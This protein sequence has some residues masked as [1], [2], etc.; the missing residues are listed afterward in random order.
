MTEPSTFQRWR[1]FF[2]GRVQGVGF[3][4][5]VARLARQHELSGF[6]CN[7]TRGVCVE[8][9]GKASSL[10]AFQQQCLSQLPPAARLQGVEREV[11]GWQ[12]EEGF[13]I[14]DS[15]A[16]DDSWLWPP[17]DLVTC[18]ACFAEFG[19]PADRRFGYPFLNCTHCGPRYSLLKALPYDRERTSM[20]TFVMCPE[21]QREYESEE[22]RRYHA[23]PTACPACGPELTGRLGAKDC[24][25]PEV[26]PAIV[27]LLAQ[28]GTV[29]L[30]GVG[31]FQLLCDATSTTAVQRLRQRKHRPHKPLAVLMED[32]SQV[33][34]HCEVS[35][36]EERWL[37]D[38]SN[39]IVLLKHRPQSSLCSEV[40][41]GS[42]ETGVMLPT[43]PL[44]L[45]L[46]RAVGRP[47]VCTS[48]N[49]SGQPLCT[50]NDDALLSLETLADGWLLHDREIEQ[51][52]DDAVMCVVRGNPFWLRCGRGIAPQVFP[53]MTTTIPTMAAGGQWK[54]SFALVDNYRCWHSPY[55]G[56]MDNLATF[57]RW[58][59]TLQRLRE[60]SGIEPALLVS[61]LHPDYQ[62]TRW[63]ERRARASNIDHLRVQH[64]H[65][66]FFSVVA[67]H[68]LT[69]PVFG[70]I[71]DGTGYGLD[72]SI[73]G[74]EGFLWTENKMERRVSLLPFALPGGDKAILEP[75]RTVLALWH[76]CEAKHP[77]PERLQSL[78][79]PQQ[80]H[81]LRQMLDKGLRSPLCSSLG[82]LFDAVAVMSGLVE[83]VSFEGEAAMRLEWSQSPESAPLS[84]P[85]VKNLDSSG[86]RFLWDWRPMFRELWRGLEKG[87]SPDAL[88]S[89]FHRALIAMGVE[90][91]QK[92][93]AGTVVLSGGCF[94]NQTL[95][96]GLSAALQEAGAEVFWNQQ[97]PCHDEGL[98][99]GQIAAVKAGFG[100][101]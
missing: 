70:L 92:Q 61:D 31:G 99:L 77:F 66:H 57:E 54:G 87:T 78:C 20:V 96:R 8:V 90:A 29:A 30:K 33:R 72:G 91:W 74:G 62:T 21:C 25:G 17:L 101:E 86:P 47:L 73:W 14:T 15:R 48:G 23:Q 37:R 43:T 12:D 68:R 60:W 84:I 50:D 49:L 52:I 28:G 81:L 95:L 26:L 4:P 22:D 32:V 79:S 59:Q 93:E 7:S 56:E 55:V 97:V 64:H 80:E 100:R 40:G 44:H 58:Q 42:P 3:R 5:F 83:K 1:L 98:P 94:Q 41:C 75:H 2:S 9:Q 85:L 10:T 6:V 46:V 67:E 13:V 76:Q 89:G 38:A 65:A 35:S 18:E 16:D 19:D 88:A 45:A 53:A 69:P 63:A 39:P 11:L 34:E 24:R 82:R 71:W 51:G 36:V 27:T